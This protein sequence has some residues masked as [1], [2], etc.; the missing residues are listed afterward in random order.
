MKR[1]TV[2]IAAFVAACAATLGLALQ[3]A[4][5]GEPKLYPLAAK[6]KLIFDETAGDIG[7][8]ACHGMDAQGDGAA[9]DIRKADEAQIKDG[10][11]HTGDMRGFG[12]TPVDIRAVAAYLAYLRKKPGI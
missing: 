10:L 11:E 5:G 9:P 1:H 4:A 8:A 12:L 6:G 3:P 7:C 2:R